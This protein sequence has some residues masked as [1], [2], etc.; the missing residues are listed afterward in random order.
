MKFKF[1]DIR[2]VDVRV[3]VRNVEQLG[4]RTMTD[5]GII[6][7]KNIPLLIKCSGRATFIIL[8][9]SVFLVKKTFYSKKQLQRVPPV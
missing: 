6:N 2:V 7:I 3:D 4:I 9:I 5:K 1:K 8:M